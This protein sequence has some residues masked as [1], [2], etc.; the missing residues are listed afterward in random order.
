MSRQ[1]PDGKPRQSRQVD[2]ARMK[3]IDQKLVTQPHHCLLV[4]I[5]QKLA[6]Q[7]QHPGGNGSP[8]PAARIKEG[9]PNQQA[10]CRFMLVLVAT[11]KA[12][13]AAQ[14]AGCPDSS[15][16]LLKLPQPEASSL[17]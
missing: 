4:K 3:H 15:P 2:T 17:T 12:H 7:P 9:F 6:T 10:W 5:D 16:S 13:M 1:Q 11:K 14:F 8:G